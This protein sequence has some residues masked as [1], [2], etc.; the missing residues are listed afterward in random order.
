MEDGSIRRLVDDAPVA[1]SATAYPLPDDM[2]LF[3]AR[4]D[5]GEAVAT[6]RLPR[7]AAEKLADSTLPAALIIGASVADAIAADAFITG[8]ND[9][10][11]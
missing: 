4:G 8:Q 5:T 9:T 6:F 7:V 2:V 3:V 11:D 1:T 10:A